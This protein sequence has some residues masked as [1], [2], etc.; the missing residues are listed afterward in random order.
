MRSIHGLLEFEPPRENFQSGITIPT[1]SHSNVWW[2][3]RGDLS[4][5]NQKSNVE[6]LYPRG[7]RWDCPNG[8][9]KEFSL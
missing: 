9:I 5:F 7:L 3:Y 8:A 1:Y 6:K 2:A 4:A